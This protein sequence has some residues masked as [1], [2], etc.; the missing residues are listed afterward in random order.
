ELLTD[1][2]TSRFAGHFVVPDSGD[3]REDLERY[4]VASARDL[5]DPDTLALVRAVIGAGGE[6]VGVCKAEREEHLEAILKRARQRGEENVPS[7]EQ[8][9][10][11]IVAPLYYRA[12]FTAQPLSAEW[13][14][15]LV[16]RLFPQ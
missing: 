9:V 11:A 10:E 7:L 3:L 12:V 6:N 1:V 15:S 16:A 2:A 4:A 13:A 14:R 8:A 5:S